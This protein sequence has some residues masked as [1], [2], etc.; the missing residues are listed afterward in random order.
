GVEV[1]HPRFLV[2]PGY[3]THQIEWLLY[4]A[5]IRKS[6]AGMRANFPFD[7]IHAHFTYPNGV[8][9]APLGRRYGVPVVI[10]DQNPWGA[11]MDQ[12]PSVRRKAIW[13]AR[14]CA[15]QIA[16]SRAVR[17]TIENYA[18]HL[19]HLRIIPDGVDGSLFTLPQTG[20]RR[21][22]DQILFVGAIRPVKG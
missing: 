10:T 17:E 9:A 2:G 11:W 14:Q 22:K 15:A 7:L 8:V 1:L 18:G 5:A 19:P 12:C 20:A 21:S 16:I 3:S 6:V 13:G 4:D